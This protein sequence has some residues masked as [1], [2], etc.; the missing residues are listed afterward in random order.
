MQKNSE[1]WLD[2]QHCMLYSYSVLYVLIHAIQK[3][4]NADDYY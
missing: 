3:E 1:I 4:M 2:K